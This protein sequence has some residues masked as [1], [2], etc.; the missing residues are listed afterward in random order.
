[1]QRHSKPSRNGNGFESGRQAR[2]ADNGSCICT[3]ATCKMI[4]I[5]LHLFLNPVAAEIGVTTGKQQL[6]F[7]FVVLIA[8]T[9]V[10]V[11]VAVVDVRIRRSPL[12]RMLMILLLLLL[13]I[14]IVIA[15]VIVIAIAIAI[16]LL[17]I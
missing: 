13:P 16:L 15:I 7:V 9:V 2:N 12:W 8:C 4:F 11:R 10:D 17:V 6:V 1:M 5:F 14:A 3:A